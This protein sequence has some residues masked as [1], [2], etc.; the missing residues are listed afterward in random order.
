MQNKDARDAVIKIFRHIAETR[1]GYNVT[2]DYN[3]YR[4]VV[5]AAMGCLQLSNNIDD[6]EKALNL[7][8]QENPNWF[9]SPQ[10]IINKLT[11]FINRRLAENDKVDN[12]LEKAKVQ[13]VNRA[14]VKTKSIVTGKP[15]G[16]FLAS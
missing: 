6:I 8:C 11:V 3:K 15:V 1:Y 4:K 2:T 9:P 5:A 7:A 14:K 10:L 16:I 13:T 12:R